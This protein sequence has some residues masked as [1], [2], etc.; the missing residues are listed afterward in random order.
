VNYQSHSAFTWSAADLLR[1]VLY[2]VGASGWI[3][4]V[5]AGIGLGYKG[6]L[7]IWLIVAALP[8]AALWSLGV[9]AARVVMRIE[10]GILLLFFAISMWA[11]LG[12]EPLGT[13]DND[14][15]V[16]FLV[17]VVGVLVGL[18]GALVAWV[19]GLFA[20]GH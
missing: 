15:P 4:I 12:P 2:I 11:G 6:L 18:I 1:R 17:M 13:P 10:I 7:V 8:W 16:R 9:R 5:A 20:T 19:S 14:G 3:A